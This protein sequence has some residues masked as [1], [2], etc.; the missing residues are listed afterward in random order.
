MFKRLE[1]FILAE[2]GLTFDEALSALST[3]QRALLVAKFNVIYRKEK[4][5]WL[6]VARSEF[7]PGRPEP[8]AIEK[9][10]LITRII[11]NYTN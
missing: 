2:T 6:S 11:T 10:I 5:A 1:K 9:T 8:C 7:Q 4:N 3:G